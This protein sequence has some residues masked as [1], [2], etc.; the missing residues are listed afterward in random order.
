VTIQLSGPLASDEA[1]VIR[2]GNSEIKPAL[3]S[4]GTNCLRFTDDQSVRITVPLDPP[5]PL[6]LPNAYSAHVVDTAGNQGAG[7]TLKA[8][9]DYFNCDQVRAD[10]SLGGKHQDV[11]SITNPKGRCENCHRTSPVTEGDGGTPR[12][13]HV[14]VPFTKPS[15]WCRRP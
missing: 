12:A 3:V 14:A 13:T 10:F 8:N 7:E 5:S 2:R 15:Y 11:S 1:L 4:C 6:P 9:F